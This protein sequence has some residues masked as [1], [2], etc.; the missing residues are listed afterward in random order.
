MTNFLNCQINNSDFYQSD[1]TGANFSGSDLK[2]TIFENSRL[3]EANFVDSKNYR[4]NPFTN[5][6]KNARFS[7]PEAITLLKSLDII[8]D[9]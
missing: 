5:K 8:I 2:D 1:L 3:S 4:I 9:D 6:I 7:M